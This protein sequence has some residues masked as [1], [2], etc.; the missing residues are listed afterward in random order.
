MR[1]RGSR[2][3]SRLRAACAEGSARGVE[4]GVIDVLNDFCA[5]QVMSTVAFEWRVNAE[6]IDDVTRLA[7]HSSPRRVFDL[8]VAALFFV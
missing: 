4:E 8:T 6:R 5:R 1:K 3:S 7:D 2:P